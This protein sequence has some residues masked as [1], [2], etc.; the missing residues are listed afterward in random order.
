MLKYWRTL[1]HSVHAALL[2]IFLT[3]L[4]LCFSG[5]WTGEKEERNILMT[6]WRTLHDTQTFTLLSIVNLFGLINMDLFAC[7]TLWKSLAHVLDIIPMLLCDGSVLC[8][9]PR[10]YYVV[11]AQNSAF[12]YWYWAILIIPEVP[13]SK[14]YIKWYFY[15]GFSSGCLTL[16]ASF[17]AF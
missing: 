10:W 9:I 11:E 3:I 13:F 2:F 6:Y 14:H 1:W 7:K 17:L 12:L 4:Y 8:D 15:T 5:K 16:F